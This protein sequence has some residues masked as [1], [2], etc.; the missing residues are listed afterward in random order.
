MRELRGQIAL[1]DGRLSAGRI[2]FAERIESI[3]AD[4]AAPQDLIIPGLID[5]QLNGAFG[6]DVMRADA[7][8]LQALARNLA[9]AGT[10]GFLATAI[11][12]P[13]DHIIAVHQRVVE[14]MR[15]QAAIGAALEAA[16]LGLHLEGPFISSLRLG[17]HPKLNLSPQGAVLER[18]L[19]LAGL[20][21]LTLA[22]ELDGGLEAIRRMHERGVIVSLGH[23][24]ATFDESSA[25]IDAGARMFTHV[26]NAMR[27]LHHRE[28]GII[29]AALRPSP[30]MAAAIPDGVHVHP[31][32]LGLIHRSRR[33]A[34]MILVSD[35][36]LL[37]GA[38]TL[39][40]DATP[41]SSAVRVERGAAWLADGTLAGSIISLLEGVRL[42]VNKSGASV[43]EASLMAATNPARLLGLNDRGAVRK[44][45][46]AD[47][48]LLDSQLG[49]KS[50]FI[51][52]REIH[53]A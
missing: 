6:V 53:A 47:L 28:P 45:T 9:K 4:P 46:R 33:T 36:I 42:M 39:G 10:T 32:M 29:G 50:V 35:S 11:T 48:L 51:A 23:S 18:I 21:L 38:P 40:A 26:F 22:P 25:A 5:L 1:A 37:A 20:R 12:S 7:P 52:G 43:A 44:G 8:A 19:G 41:G 30:A 31:Q 16:I 49:L 13:I 15:A 14:A 17:A 24:D 3:E 27:P 2:A 34:G